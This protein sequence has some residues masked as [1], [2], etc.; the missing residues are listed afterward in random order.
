MKRSSRE[1]KRIARDLLNNRYTVPMGGFVTASFISVVFKIPFSLSLGNYPAISQIVTSILAFY[2]IS[3]ID[4][5][6]RAGIIFVHLNLTRGKE[7]KFIQ[8]VEPFLHGTERYFL[9]AF[10]LSLL[11]LMSFIPV[12]AGVLVYY[13][14][15]ST[16][17]TIAVLALGIILTVLCLIL[18]I[19]NYSFVFY[20]LLD[21]PQES[22]RS[23]F[24]ENRLMMK[25]NKG[26]FFYLLLS[27]LPWLVPALCSG[28]IA[29]LWISPYMTQ[30][31]VNFY[32]DCTG[33]LNQIPVRD[34][35][36]DSRSFND[37]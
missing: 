4:M 37:L 34:Y 10:R 8:I 36:V 22:V 19:L 2:L 7:F 27:F 1:L 25:K 24:K 20:L 12:A 29:A 14:Y 13:F 15:G 18:L 21:R 23:L 31:L 33:E 35:T 6:F 11:E 32:F 3:L 9:S 28:G 30:T 17:I 26:R 5:V 16:S